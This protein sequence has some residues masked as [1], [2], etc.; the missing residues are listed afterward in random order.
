MLAIFQSDTKYNCSDINGTVAFQGG[1]FLLIY[2]VVT[3]KS[4]TFGRIGFG[5]IAS[6]KELSE[7]QDIKQSVMPRYVLKTIAILS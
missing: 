2:M 7:K 1:L 4:K 3:L 6:G 5:K